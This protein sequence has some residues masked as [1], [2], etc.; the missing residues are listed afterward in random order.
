MTYNTAT[1]AA[2]KTF[3]TVNSLHNKIFSDH[4][5]K[6]NKYLFLRII[7]VALSFQYTS[8]YIMYLH[9]E[10]NRSNTQRKI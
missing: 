3:V 8:I 5:N 6:G 4:L 9:L 1:G 2:E 7:K 10:S